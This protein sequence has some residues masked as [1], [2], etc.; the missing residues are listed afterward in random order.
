MRERELK[1]KS[2]GF[3]M[4]KKW[5]WERVETWSELSE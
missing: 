1:I 3:N 2:K 4:G 5:L